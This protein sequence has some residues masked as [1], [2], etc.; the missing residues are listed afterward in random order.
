MNE[1]IFLF[2]TNIFIF[3]LCGGMFMIIP[4]LTRKSLLFGVKIPQAQANCPEAA[5]MKK[6]Y[7][8]TCLLGSVVILAICIV[9]FILIPEWT[10]F[11]TMYLWLLIIPVYFIAFV[12]NWKKA[13]RLKAD[14]GWQ[15]SNVMFAETKSSHTRGNLHALPWGWYIASFV[16]VVVTAVLAVAR[17]PHLPDMIPGHMDAN[18]Q[19]TRYV[20]KTM[21]SVL[22]MPL[23]NVATLLIM[24]FAGIAIEKAKLQMD[25]GNL[26]ISFM[27]HRI[28]RKRMGNAMGFLALAT[29]LLVGVVGLPIIFDVPSQI[30]LTLFWGS[31]VLVAVPLIVLILVVIKTGQ[32][33]CKVK[34]ELSE[35]DM[36]D[37]AQQTTAPEMSKAV[38]RGDDKYWKLGMFYYN[39]EDPAI[40]VEDRFGTNIGFNYGRLPVQIGMALLGVGLVVLYV[41]LTVVLVRM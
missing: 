10:L 21:F 25:P 6:Q 34:I 30:G 20:P 33:G 41:W 26:R 4:H 12:P 23:I 32:G 1:N 36:E 37:A 2:A 28:Y 7:V 24:L 35:S 16:I 18:M 39:P 15:V 8:L 17:Y 3:V 38:G 13:V 27:Q 22:M 9:Q 31:M 40:V 19:A 29:V 11:A 5:A 14:K